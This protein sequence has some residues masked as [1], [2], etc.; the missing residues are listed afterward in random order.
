MDFRRLTREFIMSEARKAPPSAE[1]FIQSISETLSSL[2]P[3]TRKD[4]R[5]IELAKA[6]LREINRHVRRLQEEVSTLQEQI[7]ILEEN[8]N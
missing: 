6:N 3:S 5:R 7:N 8:R 4:E 2:R 1:S